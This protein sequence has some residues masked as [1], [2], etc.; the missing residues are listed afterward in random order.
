MSRSCHA[1]IAVLFAVSVFLSIGAVGSC[2]GST[3]PSTLKPEGEPC[4][5][6]NECQAGLVCAAGT[7]RA[8]GDAGAD[9]GRDAGDAPSD[10]SRD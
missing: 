8:E 7:C 10:A 3:A 2:S 9:A 5:R 6:T 1:A 4:T